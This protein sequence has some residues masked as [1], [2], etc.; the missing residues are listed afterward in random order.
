VSLTTAPV[1]WYAARAAGIV[2][3][4][5]LTCA[6]VVG[7]LQASKLRFR[8]WP[9]FALRD[10]HRFLGLLVGT[11]VAV[12]VVTVALDSYARLSLTSLLVPFTGGY[13]PFWTGLGVAAAEL[14]LALA[15]TNRLKRRLPHRFWRRAH[16]L[17]FAV[18]GAA[19]VHLLGTGSD[20]GTV[21]L[22]GLTLGSVL[23]VGWTLAL[24]VATAR[25]PPG[26]ART[27]PRP[28][29]RRAASRPAASRPPG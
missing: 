22:L 28:P 6:V 25:R 12:H 29:T 15:V 19:T 23:A 4:L 5:L 3:Y 24:R 18:W 9:A 11:F 8:H 17:Y 13:R 20:R 14:M 21:W 16:Y 7:M 26:S 1:D 27:S 10:V 2:A